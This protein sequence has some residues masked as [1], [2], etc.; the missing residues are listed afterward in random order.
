MDFVLTDEQTAIGD[1]ASQILT[2]RSTPER[3]REIEGGDDWFDADL[4]AELAKADLLGLCLP[5]AHGGGGFGP[6]EL[7]LLLEQVGKAVAP[8][9]VHATLAL[10]ALPLAEF[11]SAEQQ[12]AWLPGVATGRSSMGRSA[13]ARVRTFSGSCSAYFAHSSRS[14]RS[15]SGPT[16]GCIDSAWSSPCSS[17]ALE[18]ISKISRTSFLMV[19]GTMPCSVLYAS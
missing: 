5:T 10:G 19:L 11:G 7:A 2:E 9:P 12:A 15:P 8:V 4:W 17:G 3:V 13:R 16:T 6:F 14:E 1:L 18:V